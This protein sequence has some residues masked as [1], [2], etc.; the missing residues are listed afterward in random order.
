MIDVIGKLSFDADFLLFLAQRG[1]VRYV[2]VLDGL[3]PL[4]VEADNVIRYRAKL[5]IG[6]RL[7]IIKGLSLLGL[8]RKTI[9]AFYVLAKP[10]C[11]KIGKYTHDKTH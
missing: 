8:C 2:P 10:S 5:V 7:V 9:E 3:L 11:G 6:E 4:G 1:I